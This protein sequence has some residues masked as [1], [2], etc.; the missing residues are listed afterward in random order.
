MVIPTIG[1]LSGI[2]SIRA[3]FLFRVGSSFHQEYLNGVLLYIVLLCMGGFLCFYLLPHFSLLR[4]PKVC[5]ALS[6]AALFFAGAWCYTRQNNLVVLPANNKSTIFYGKVE[7]VTPTKSER[8]MRLNIKLLSFRQEEENTPCNTNVF[9]YVPIERYDP[10]L[11]AGATILT[12]SRI[13]NTTSESL[14]TQQGNMP[15]S[16]FIS[17]Y[18][19]FHYIPIRPS[20]PTRLHDRLLLSLK[21]N[22]RDPNSFAL[23]GG[24]SIGN[25]EAFDPELKSAYAGAG[26]SH[27]LA[28]SGL[29]TGI[30]YSIIFSLCNFLLPGNKRTKLILKQTLTLGSITVFAA[31]A[32]FTPSITRALLMITLSMAG[33]WMLRPVPSIQMLFSTAF[34]IC[35]INPAA[36]FEVSFQLSFCAVLAILTIQSP[37]QRLWHPKTKVG[38]Y[39]W[40]LTCVSIAAQ[41]GTAPLAYHYFGT[42]PYL[43]LLTNLFVIPLT[44]VLLYL[45]CVWLVLGNL[46]VIG[47]ALLWAMEQTAGLM[48]RGVI[49]IDKLI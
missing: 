2:L 32:G 39:V 24:L 18:D 6:V 46:P 42:F 13:Q 22:I 49:W 5:Y 28:V 12:A 33:K 47:N 16:I 31:I 45:L 19:S 8:F 35:A 38:K 30:I 21:D 23:I 29:H 1:Y 7:R 17:R 4:F 36:L 43:F 15:P 44:G 9:I 27:V 37:L 14:S 41:A 25:K 34:I 26:A 3:L 11:Q 40:S 10:K 48:N 20:F